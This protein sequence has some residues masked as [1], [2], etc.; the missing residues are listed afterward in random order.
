MPS[1]IGNKPNQVPSN[2]DLGTLAFQDHD[3]VRITGGT[4]ALNNLTVDGTTLVVDSTNDR[5]GVGTASPTQALD[6]V[7]AVRVLNS[8]GN[9]S[10]FL[11]GDTNTASIQQNGG[12]LYFNSNTNT[13]G[14]GYIWRSSSSLTERMRLDSSG[15]LGVGTASPVVRATISGTDSNPPALGTAAG[16]ALFLR[17]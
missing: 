7:G 6:V 12:N 2:G 17:H 9:Q 10:F 15:N 1:L 14:G 5:V 3:S 16:T 4:A 11:T 13:T 8:G